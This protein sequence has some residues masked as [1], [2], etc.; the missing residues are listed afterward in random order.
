MYI[1]IYI[2]MY[3]IIVYILYTVYKSGA[4]RYCL[5]VDEHV[6]PI[7]IPCTFIYIFLFITLFTVCPRV[8]C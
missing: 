5:V 7:G 4:M 8:L 1:Y 6:H 3:Y 2:Y